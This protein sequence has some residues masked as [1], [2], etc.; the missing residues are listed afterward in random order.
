[1]GQE[2]IFKKELAELLRLGKS[3]GNHLSEEQV[4]AAFPDSGIDESKISFIYEY[5]IQ[6]KI[7]VDA[8]FDPD[9]VMSEEDKDFLAMFLEE[10]EELPKVTEEEREQII[11]SAMA[12]DADAAN[13]LLEIFLP[14][15]AE[16]A[17]LYAGQGV[18][19]E[20]LI[21]EGNVALAAA[22]SMTGC[23]EK[24]EDAE[25]FFAGMIMDAMEVLI[26]AEA[27]EKE[28][29][30]KILEQVNRVSMAAEELYTQM[31]RKITPDELAEETD[32]TVAEIEEAFRLSG[33]QIDT[34]QMPDT[35]QA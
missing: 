9:E 33:S 28:K 2:E 23:V 3:Q 20:D 6:N 14:K 26:S 10:L 24:P 19:M 15:V 7:A 22:V 32:L 13:R 30:N 18:L 16:I 8:D 12:D 31:R 11:L 25:G 27:D 1:M 29:D 5:L 17:K 4:K 34:L 21:G 35:E